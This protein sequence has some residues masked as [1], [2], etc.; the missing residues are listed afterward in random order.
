[1]KIGIFIENP[2][3][4]Y[5]L[6]KELRL[7]NLDFVDLHESDYKNI[8]VVITDTEKEFKN[9][10]RESDP[11]RAVRRALSYLYGKEKF[12]EI[13]IGIDPGERTGVVVLG[14]GY[15]L[16]G[17]E[18]TSPNK[19]RSIIDKIYR[20][21]SPSKFLIKIGGGDIHRRNIIINSLY[22]DYEV[23]IINEDKTTSIKNRN[24]EAARKIATKNG[25]FIK[26]NIKNK[27]KSGQIKDVQRI[28]RIQSNN[29]ITISK[30]LAILVIK[31]IITLEEAINL[32]K[33]KK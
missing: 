20:D 19:V 8:A 16:E 23:E 17:F 4:Y 31:G 3:Y 29:E 10:I 28:S 7:R 11:E 6:L 14:D 27:I 2:K 1:M 25:K 5:I 30:E 12:D 33:R 18:I 22:R 24:I 21:Y 9:T 13:I 26:K 32:E 15:M